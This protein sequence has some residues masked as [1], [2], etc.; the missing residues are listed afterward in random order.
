MGN[1]ILSGSEFQDVRGCWIFYCEKF[2]LCQGSRCDHA[3]PSEGYLHTGLTF[4]LCRENQHFTPRIVTLSS[5]EGKC[6]GLT[7]WYTQE[8]WNLL[9]SSG[10]S[11]RDSSCNLLASADRNRSP[12]SIPSGSAQ[13]GFA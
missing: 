4:G 6:L 1:F 9:T 5:K 3:D 7:V 11:H 2:P 8:L 10:R 12:S 13:P